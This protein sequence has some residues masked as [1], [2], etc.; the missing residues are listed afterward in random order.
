MFNKFKKF[1]KFNIQTKGVKRVPV[2]Q[3]IP[4]GALTDENTN[5][6]ILNGNYLILGE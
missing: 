1:K 2:V 6:I 3:P 4:D 5:I